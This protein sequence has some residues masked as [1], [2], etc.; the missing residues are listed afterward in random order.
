[1][2]MEGTVFT[3]SL[4]GMKNVKSEQGEMLTKPFLDVCK[5]ILPVIGICCFC[6]AIHFLCYIDKLS[7][8]NDFLIKILSFFVFLALALNYYGLL[9]NYSMHMQFVVDLYSY[10]LLIVL[11]ETD[12]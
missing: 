3:P 2:E 6:F 8:L 9:S 7:Y 5:L 4:E 11:T 1:V 10:M 12:I